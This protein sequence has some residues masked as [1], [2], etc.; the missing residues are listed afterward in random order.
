[1]IYIQQL[2]TEEILT[3]NEMHRNHPRYLSRRRAHALVLSHQGIS[4]PMLCS[5][6][7][8]CRQTVST[9]FSNWELKGICGLVDEPGR[10]RPSLLTDSQK[11]DAVKRI[12]KS[13]RSLRTVFSAIETELGIVLSIDTLKLICKQAGLVWKRVRKSLRKKR[14]QEDFDAAK[15]E[16]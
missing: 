14:N 16:I 6:Y 5:T 15:K 13:P 2:S 1:M 4:V 7:N 3:L 10:G 12:K 8:V 9:W 11:N